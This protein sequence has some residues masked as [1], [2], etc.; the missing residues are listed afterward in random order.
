LGG[1]Y[2]SGSDFG[3]TLAAPQDFGGVSTQQ[4]RVH[5]DPYFSK[6]IELTAL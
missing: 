5:N 6:K 3:F 4:K 2:F 1:F